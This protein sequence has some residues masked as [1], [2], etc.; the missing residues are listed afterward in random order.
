MCNPGGER[1]S[2]LTEDR[3]GF[4]S[5]QTKRHNLCSSAG[6]QSS[7]HPGAR[8]SLTAELKVGLKNHMRATI[9]MIYILN[10]R[11]QHTTPSSGFCSNPPRHYGSVGVVKGSDRKWNYG[12]NLEEDTEGTAMIYC[13]SSTRFKN[14]TNVQHHIQ[15][16]GHQGRESTGNRLGTWNWFWFWFWANR[17]M[18]DRHNR[19]INLIL[20]IVQLSSV[21]D[22][23]PKAPSSQPQQPQPLPLPPSK[24]FCVVG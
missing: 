2:I 16:N 24:P 14:D 17:D 13:L 15:V 22:E 4:N 18:A 10:R 3:S 8:S 7:K 6:L 5:S 21:S 1:S 9:F 12:N 11:L 23:T 20:L 19:T